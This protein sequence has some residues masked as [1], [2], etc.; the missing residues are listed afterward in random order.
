MGFISAV[1]LRI[2]GKIRVRE[3]RVIDETGKSLGV[4]ATSEAVTMAEDKGLDLVEV[5]PAAK[6]QVCKFID[7][8]KYKY[9]MTKKE[10]EAKKKQHVIV[11][12]EIQVRPNI[13]PHDLEIKLNHAIEFLDKG[14]KVKFVIRFRG[15]ELEYKAQKGAEMTTKIMQKIADRAEI[16]NEPDKQER[17]IIF[18]VVP[19]KK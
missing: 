10:K 19:K 6:P 14:Y 11:V 12:K 5:S 2:N 17:S 1:E 13:D 7:Y 15:R 4:F 8:G 18:Y 16:E 3:V 9:E